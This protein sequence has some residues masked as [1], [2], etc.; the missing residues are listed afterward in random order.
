MREEF[1]LNYDE[2]IDM[3]KFYE[4][5]KLIRKEQD[6]KL[7]GSVDYWEYYDEK[8]VLERIGVD[9]DGD[10]EIDDWHPGKD[11]SKI[12]DPESGG[13]LRRRTAASRRLGQG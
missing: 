5:G 10:G 8:E 11:K 7:D 4:D 3:T 13:A 9:H 2:K 12:A 6:A 1:D